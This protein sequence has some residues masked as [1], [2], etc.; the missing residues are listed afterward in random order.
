MESH[1]FSCERFSRSI[2]LII[3]PRGSF[4]EIC[5][6]VA[7]TLTF[8]QCTDVVRLLRRQAHAQS[9]NSHDA[10]AVNCK[11]QELRDDVRRYA[12][13]GVNLR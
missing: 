10:E 4:T 5:L 3:H 13:V 12:V 7:Q 9:I 11:R 6:V 1:L 2:G 8:S